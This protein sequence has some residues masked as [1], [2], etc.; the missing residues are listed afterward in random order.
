MRFF[1]LKGLIATGLAMGFIAAMPLHASVI[2]A[3]N[4][5]QGVFDPDP[6]S[7]PDASGTRTVS[8]SVGDLRGAA[9][10]ILDV[11][12]TIEFMKC[13]DVTAA[14]TTPL[15]ASCPDHI[16]SAFAREII[17]RLTSP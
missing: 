11:N 17:F 16:N 15:P 12:V 14:L 7:G 2:S 8:F 13:A 10:T 3:S 5:T 9:N 6:G 1:E 4:S